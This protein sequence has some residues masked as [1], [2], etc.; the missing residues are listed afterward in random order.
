MT[1]TQGKELAE[2]YRQAFP[3]KLENEKWVVAATIGLVVI[4]KNTTEEDIAKNPEDYDWKFGFIRNPNL[5]KE[6]DANKTP[7]ES[8]QDKWSNS[9]GVLKCE[10]AFDSGN[11]AVRTGN[12]KLAK[13][14]ISMIELYLKY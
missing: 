3:N 8:T 4:A 5:Q 2:L 10:L 7:E 1:Y 14:F 6:L 12:Y 11:V 9:A 13:Q